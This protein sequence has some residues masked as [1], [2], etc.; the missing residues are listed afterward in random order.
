M[1]SDAGHIKP[2]KQWPWGT[3]GPEA[4]AT[5]ARLR[6]TAKA[7]AP[8]CALVASAHRQRGELALETLSIS[9]KKRQIDPAKLDK[10]PHPSARRFA[11][12]NQQGFDNVLHP[13]RRRQGH[14]QDSS[15]GTSRH[16]KR[17]DFSTKERTW[18][19]GGGP[20]GTASR[21]SACQPWG[22]NG[23]RKFDG[24]CGAN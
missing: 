16:Q 15:G 1:I 9:V 21:L 24:I 18:A 10:L 2:A 4:D 5:S 14:W 13:H 22:A 11:R 8:A 17:N 3:L 23:L 12:K 7:R 20:G 6:R 19:M